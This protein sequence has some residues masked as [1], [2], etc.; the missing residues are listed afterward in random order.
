MHIA[1]DNKSLEVASLLIEAGCDIN[2]IA[3]SFPDMSPVS[4]SGSIDYRSPLQSPVKVLSSNS[5]VI[6]VAPLHI[7]IRRRHKDM[8]KLFLNHHADLHV[9][10]SSGETP[11]QLAAK[12]LNANSDIYTELCEQAQAALMN[13]DSTK[14]VAS[15]LPPIR[16]S[17]SVS[18]IPP[19]VNLKTIP[20][21][22]G[23]PEINVKKVIQGNAEEDDDIEVITIHN[24]I[25][26]PD[27]V[28]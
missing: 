1:V 21:E 2:A 15:D 19:A 16:A 5:L 3:T 17:A 22:S 8:V 6:F 13:S 24:D 14:D 26:P 23:R 11:L 27:N 9:M 25:R 4:S 28:S 12:I 10:D 20:N 7:A 18:L